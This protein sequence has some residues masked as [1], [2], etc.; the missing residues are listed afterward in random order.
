MASRFAPKKDE[1][2]RLYWDKDGDEARFIRFLKL[3][4]ELAAA[5]APYESPR[6]AAIGPDLADLR[7]PIS[8]G[9]ATQLPRLFFF[10]KCID[11]L[12]GPRP[13][14]GAARL[15]CPILTH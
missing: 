3:S 9:F 15:S 11:P 12:R 10:S 8:R 7:Q 5:R 2:G 14:G 6:L 13:S 4:G 1:R